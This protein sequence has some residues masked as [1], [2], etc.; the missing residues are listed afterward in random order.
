[1]QEDVKPIPGRKSFLT[2]NGKAVRPERL[3]RFCDELVDGCLDAEVIDMYDF[4]LG[5]AA[6]IDAV[7]RGTVDFDGSATE[8]ARQAY[9]DIHNITTR[10]NKVTNIMQEVWE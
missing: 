6:G 4:A 3:S 8:V 7:S 1:M 5:F 9:R 10:P 2:G